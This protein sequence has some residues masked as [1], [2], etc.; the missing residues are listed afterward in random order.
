MS[1]AIGAIRSRAK[2]AAAQRS[3][4]A[5]AKRSHDA[6]KRSRAAL[7]RAIAVD[8]AKRA[9]RDVLYVLR[10]VKVQKFPLTAEQDKLVQELE[11]VL[12]TNIGHSD[13]LRTCVGKFLQ[14]AHLCVPLVKERDALLGIIYK[15]CARFN[16]IL[17]FCG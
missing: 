8:A 10:S 11:T 1:R 14:S 12:N 6:A 17:S 9:A 3:R 13:N 4:R 15:S 16:A 2:A 5:A 7:R